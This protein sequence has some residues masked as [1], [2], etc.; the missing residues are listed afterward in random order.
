MRQIHARNE[1]SSLQPLSV[2]DIPKMRHL[3]PNAAASTRNQELNDMIGFAD[4]NADKS[5]GTQ[6]RFFKPAQDFE[7]ANV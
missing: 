4:P 6:K 1:S 5:F 7:S 3:S 2:G